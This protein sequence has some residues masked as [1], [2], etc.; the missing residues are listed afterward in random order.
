MQLQWDVQPLPGLTRR[1]AGSVIDRSVI[2]D[3]WADDRPG[4]LI[5]LYALR[6]PHG[7]AGYFAEAIR[8]GVTIAHRFFLLNDEGLEAVDPAPALRKLRRARRGWPGIREL[9]RLATS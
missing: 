9:L 5:T 8:D 1:S 7:D 2:L 4:V 3:Q 6:D